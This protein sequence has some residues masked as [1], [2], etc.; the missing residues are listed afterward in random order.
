MAATSHPVI[1]TSFR[2]KG[3]AEGDSANWGTPDRIDRTH[4]DAVLQNV[5]FKGGHGSLVVTQAL[6]IASTE[7]SH[8]IHADDNWSIT[9][10]TKLRTSDC[11]RYGRRSVIA[12]LAI[13]LSTK[14]ARQI[15]L[16]LRTAVVAP[17][18]NPLPSSGATQRHPY[19][20]V[21]SRDSL[22]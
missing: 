22:F 13:G 11:E 10:A 2:K 14:R 21:L 18:D 16:S 4:V 5:P 6:L 1:K 12:S 9:K 20:P 19:L 8:F 3:C 15:H 7:T 17:P